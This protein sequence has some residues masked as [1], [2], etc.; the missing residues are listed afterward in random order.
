MLRKN[1]S[2]SLLPLIM[3][4]SFHAEA[5]TITNNNWTP[6]GCGPAPVAASLNLTNLDVYNASVG[7]VNDFRKNNRTYVD[8][9]IHEANS[10]I[11]S[12]TKSAKSAQQAAH[13]ADDKIIEDEKVAEKKFPK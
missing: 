7:A 10:D 4:A 3:V 9:L 2:K 6:S 12:I 8:C 1:I 13:D 5:G 11:Q